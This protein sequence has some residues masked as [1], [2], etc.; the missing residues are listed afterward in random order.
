[1]NSQG[2]HNEPGQ[3]S[4]HRTHEELQNSSEASPCRSSN[5]WKWPSFTN[6]LS[7]L[8]LVL[9]LASCLTVT[10][11]Q[12]ENEVR[13]ENSRLFAT[14][15]EAM[16]NFASLAAEKVNVISHRS[17][18]TFGESGFFFKM[19]LFFF[20]PKQLVV[21]QPLSPL[22]PGH[23]WPFAGDQGHLHVQLATSTHISHVTIGHI[24]KV[25]S[26]SGDI[27][28][29]PREF[30][31]YGMETLN[32]KKKLLGTFIY[33]ENGPSFQTFALSN[34][35]QNQDIYR[36]VLLQVHSNWESGYCCRCP[37]RC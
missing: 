11:L 4:A 24:S 16:P 23:C 31:V 14:E 37:A 20:P 27:S 13:N 9:F 5:S 34:Q 30:S 8:V 33:D 10:K 26:C 32:A 21:L 29:A 25:Q 7:V 15:A 28:S 6:V 35:D 1:M 2:F 19:I 12:R 3:H 18:N 22:I 36:H 17:S